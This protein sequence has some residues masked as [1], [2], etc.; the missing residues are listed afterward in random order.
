MDGFVTYTEGC[1]GTPN[2][3]C[4]CV[5]ATPTGSCNCSDWASPN[6]TNTQWVHKYVQWFYALKA[7]YPQLLWVNNI[8]TSFANEI[9]NISN[10]R[11]IEGS[12]NLAASPGLNS[13][14]DGTFPISN[15]V[16]YIASCESEATLVQRSVPSQSS[17]VIALGDLAS[18]LGLVGVG[19]SESILRICGH[20]S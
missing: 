7:K 2:V 6:A 9:Q 8:D 13:I 16:N 4:E 5:P 14:I 3:A 11:Q 10:G 17:I 15:Y 19:R 18:C 12:Y 1:K 20:R